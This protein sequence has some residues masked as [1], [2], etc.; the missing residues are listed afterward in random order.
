M[1]RW[2]WRRRPPGRPPA[3]EIAGARTGTLLAPY[4][5]EL[6]L[7]PTAPARWAQDGGDETDALQLYRS[8]LRDERCAAALDQRLNAAI[9]RPWEVMPGGDGRRDRIAAEDLAEQLGA[10]QFNRICRQLLHGVWYGWAVGEA[11]WRPGDGRVELEDIVVRS[12]D[13]F[14]WGPSKELLL[15]TWS[16]PQGEPVPAAKFIVLHRAGEHDD[17]PW[18]PGLAR[19]CYWPVHL[20][21]H[22]IQFWSVA[23]EKFGAPTAKASYPRN[24]TEAEKRRLLEVLQSLATGVGVAVP[25]GQDIELM[26]TAQRAGGDFEAFVGYLDRSITTTILGQSSTTDQGPWRGT[27]EVQKDVR[28][29]TVAA[30]TRL[31]DDTLNGTVARWLTAWNHPGAAVPRIRHDADPPEDLDARAVRERTIAETAGIRPTL[32]HIREVYGGDW[33]E[34]PA[35]AGPE[36]A[37]AGADPPF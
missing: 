16:A 29:E 22:G 2:P 1:A 18:S 32:D 30:D 11:M 21:R 7:H 6:P 25:E 4:I 28:D 23:L 36:A 13:R 33:E 34:L 8:V 19:W 37:L 12:L 10:L 20:K 35:E 27:A 9:S 3:G 14:W 15:R 5:G 31:L 17:L 24:A 26:A